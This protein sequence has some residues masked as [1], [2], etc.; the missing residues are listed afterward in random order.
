MYDLI[1]IGAGPGGYEAA[2][3]AGRMGRKTALIEREHLGGACLNVGCIPTKT[4]LRSA[5]LFAECRN[6]NAYGVEISSAAFNLGAVAE[7]RGRVVK[8]L[9]RGVEGLLKRSGVEIIKG[10]A[11]LASR[12]TVQVEKDAYKAR[13][14]LIATGSRPAVPPIPG[15]DSGGVLD[16]TGVLSLMK[17]PKKAAIMGGGYVGLEFASFFAATGVDVTVIEML[18]QIAAGS[19]HDIAHRLQLALK[20]AG[21]AFKTSHTITAIEEGKVR[22][23]DSSGTQIKIRADCVVNALGRVPVVDGL[24]LEAAGVDF[25]S[26][27]IRTSDRGNTNVPGIW[28]CGDVTGR[29]MLAHA[30]TR[31][32]IV[33]VNNMFAGKDR[34]RYNAIPSVIY[35]H[36]EVA[37]VGRTEN[38]LKAEGVEYNK[39]VAPM[40]VAGRFLVENEG[41]NGFI[42]VLAGARYRE[43]LGVHA[44]GNLSSEFIAAAAQM[45]EMEMCVEDVKAVVYPHPTVAEALKHAIMELA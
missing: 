23:E 14:I 35:T 19:D 21:I 29:R 17:L 22:C 1:V 10:H 8:A 12:D 16:S 25:D 39:S 34:I 36:P 43:I 37:S 15:I 2:A 31:E 9:K 24:G 11:R 45:I 44:L 26:K 27:G 13:N 30:A 20:A 7:R 18:P 5:N 28:A 6:A 41:A 32:G 42:K 38:E 3:A 40:A 33:A 4:Y